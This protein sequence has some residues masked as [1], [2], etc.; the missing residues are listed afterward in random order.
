MFNINSVMQPSCGLSTQN[1]ARVE[2][3]A[4][5]LWLFAVVATTLT[6]EL[7]RDET[8]EY[9]MAI[10]T[11]SFAD[12]FN[13]AKYD[14][15]PLLWRTILMA[16]H[17][18]IPH[19]VI[20]QM[21]SLTIGYLT[22]HLFVKYSPL[23]LVIKVLFI[24]GVVPFATDTVDARDYGISM[25]LFFILALLY[26]KTERHPILIGVILFFQANSNQYGMYLSGL[27]LAGW[28]ADHGFAVLRD[29]RFVLA[30]VIA[31]VGIFISFYSTRMDAESVFCTP[32]FLAR[33]DIAKVLV[34]ALHHPGEFIYYILNIKNIVY[35][36]IFVIALIVGI[37]VVRPYLGLAMILAVFFFNVVAIAFIYP[38]TRHQGV[39]LGFFLALIWITQ[40]GL[41]HNNR[42]GL[43]KHA[44]T[45]FYGV[46]V[47]ALL[48]FLVHE[49]WING[50]IV[51]EEA[52]VEKS[53][54]LAIGHYL[55]TNSQLK[56]AILIGSP[57][58]AIEPVAYYSGS[59][60]YLVKEQC[61]RNFVK[62]SREFD[63]TANLPDMLAAAERLN[64]EHHVPIIILLGYFGMKEGVT[65]PTIY[66]GNFNIN[67]VEAFKAK[68]VKL[69]EFNT[70]LG[71]ENFQ[72]FLYLPQNEL[73]SYKAKYMEFR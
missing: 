24:F 33:I 46:L 12:Y 37:T 17:W 14:G 10:G 43:F 25:L 44:K 41:R 65:V 29:K 27:F 19:P 35:R 42:P 69:A 21:A 47:V 56:N 7:W 68:T 63:T 67:G 28:I 32:E 60:M 59:R 64:A 50:L 34:K 18:L 2:N 23:P 45:I 53:S 1:G 16:M 3:G 72:V 52:K 4:L 70:S 48:P 15:H 55:R 62:F 66:R 8:R 39:L 54:A 30:A 31:M 22:V 49:V 51:Q 40:D 9:L 57:D 20:L 61:F 73:L 36:D 6:H 5:A 58:Y 13:F 26:P 11:D 71:D 38:Q